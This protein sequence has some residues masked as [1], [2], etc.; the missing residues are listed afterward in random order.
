MRPVAMLVSGMALLA[1]APVAARG[2]QLPLLTPSLTGPPPRSLDYSTRAMLSDVSPSRSQFIAAFPVS[3]AATIGVGRFY[4]MPRK[5]M[6][7]PEQAGVLEVKKPRRAAVG[8]SL[9]F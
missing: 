1:A 6:G 7:P 2:P 9:K 3:P 4:S 5:R 8:L